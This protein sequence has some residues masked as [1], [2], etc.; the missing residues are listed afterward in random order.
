MILGAS[1]FSF[2]GIASAVDPADVPPVNLTKAPD[3]GGP[4]GAFKI[5]Q[6]DGPAKLNDISTHRVKN[7]DGS[8][9]VET[10]NGVPWTP[11]PK[12]V[13]C[14]FR[15]LMIQVQFLINAAVVIG[16][17]AALIGFA[18]AGFLY[19]TGTQA[20]LKKAHTIFPKILW[21]FVIMLAAWFI[22]YQIL[23]W[24]TPGASAY[25]PQ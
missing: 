6:C 16:V 3:A 1:L 11:D 19:I 17:L 18:Y 9:Q 12:F 5:L 4:F 24:L 15:G 2:A 7:T 21:G 14:D 8:W 22:V 20:N 23:A 13:P 10:V 25:L